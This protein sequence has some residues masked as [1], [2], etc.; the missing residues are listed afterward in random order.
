M[1]CNGAQ[2]KKLRAQLGFTQEKLSAMSDVNIR[3]IQRAEN[4]EPLELETFN[5]IAQALNTTPLAIQSRRVDDDADSNENGFLIL[6]PTVEGAKLVLAVRNSFEA[7]IEYDAEPTDDT[8]E[9][10]VELVEKLN[11]VSP[12]RWTYPWL[13]FGDGKPTDGEVLRIQLEVTK[14]IN[15]LAANG[16][17]VFLGSYIAARYTPVIKGTTVYRTEKQSPQN[18]VGVRISNTGLD[19][20][21]I[22]VSDEWK[23]PAKSSKQLEDFSR[24]DFDDEIPF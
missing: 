3:T 2:I 6:R 19:R 12:K 15:H 17:D 20:I 1:Y 7:I 9:T 8:I 21:K 13:A 10:M 14:H 5:Q 4:G 11:E 23:E 24:P 16:V 22:A 18:V